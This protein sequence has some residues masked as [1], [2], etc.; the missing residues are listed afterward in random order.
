M[1]LP[2][3]AVEMPRRRQQ[4]TPQATEASDKPRLRSRAAH[5]LD[6]LTNQEIA[7]MI[8]TTLY[9]QD[10]QRAYKIFYARQQY[11]E[12]DLLELFITA[13]AKRKGC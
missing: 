7:D 10:I 3:G 11:C 5:N 2:K 1:I 4:N 9:Q 6:A 13:L 12:E 8:A